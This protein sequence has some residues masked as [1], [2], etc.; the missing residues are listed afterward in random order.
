MDILQSAEGLVKEGLK[1]RVRE[2]LAGSNL[3]AS[4]QCQNSQYFE[5]RKAVT[6]HDGVQISFHEFFL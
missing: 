1:V 2:R 3:Q 5:L 6:S 4:T